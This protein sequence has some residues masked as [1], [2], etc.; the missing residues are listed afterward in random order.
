MK[1]SKKHLCLQKTILTLALFG[2]IFGLSVPVWAEDNTEEITPGIEWDGQIED[3][4]NNEITAPTTDES[5]NNT[6]APAPEISEEP[7]ETPATPELTVEKVTNTTTPPARANTGGVTYSVVPAAKTTETTQSPE[8]TP[9]IVKESE[10]EKPQMITADGKIVEVIEILETPEGETEEI[11]VPITATKKTTL[12]TNKRISLM[13]LAT[14]GIIFF[15]GII[16]WASLL[17]HRINRAEKSVQ[18]K[19]NLEII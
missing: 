15:T 5:N 14:S 7:K 12:D 1:I 11:E 8:P 13:A 19:N 18:I 9:E 3:P 10:V 6:P 16:I 4:T 17:L 2:L